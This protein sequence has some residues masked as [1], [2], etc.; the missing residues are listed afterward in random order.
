[1]GRSRP[2]R[3]ES[4]AVA[5]EFAILV[6]IMLIIV[7]GIIDFGVA[8]NRSMMLDNAAREGARKGSLGAT[9]TEIRNVVASDTQGIPGT[10]HV[11]VT[12]RTPMGVACS[13]YDSQAESGGSVRVTVSYDHPWVTP[14]AS[15]LGFGE[16]L[17]LQEYTEMRIE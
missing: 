11:D 1:M 7:F 13:S 2:K 6:P 16:K 9:S 12:C 14:I 5:V 3:D 10:V 15:M 8:I 17:H 4:G